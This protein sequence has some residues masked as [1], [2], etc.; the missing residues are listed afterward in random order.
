M[1]VGRILTLVL[2]AWGF[3][4][5]VRAS[6]RT[7]P[8]AGR[9]VF[10]GAATPHATSI[11]LD[12]AALGLGSVNQ[13]Y[14]AVTGALDQLSIQLDGVDPATGASTG[15]GPRVRDAELGAG[16]TIALVYH[17]A[18]DFT[19]GFE[20]HSAPPESF[21]T[22]QRALQ[23]Q[24]LGGGE[25]D[26]AA[27]AG[28]SYKVANELFV[29][30]SLSHQNTLLK[31]DYVRDS[32]LEGATGPSAICNDIAAC[33]FGNADAAETWHVDVRSPTLSTSNL[34]VN[35]GAVVQI[36][37]DV[38]L[39]VAYHTPPESGV[40]TELAGH[41]VI[42]RAPRDVRADPDHL[43]QIRGQ[44][45]VEVQF[46]ASV[47]AELRARL[48][49]ELDLHVGGRWEDLSRLSAY[50]VRAYGSTLPRFG[51]PEWTERPRGLHDAFA[52]WAGAEQIDHGQTLRFGGRAGFETAS[53]TAERT[54]PL[55]ISPA[56][57]TLDV[58]AQL[59]I[60]HGLIA[61]L[62][63]GLQY[64]PTVTV[65]DSA[66]DPRDRVICSAKN[67]DYDAPE[68]A[69]VRNGYAISTAAGT[70]DRLQH[71]VRFALRYEL[72]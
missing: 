72:Q 11:G 62:S 23:Y 44:S 33:G 29:G 68:C 54:S 12:P 43:A 70:Y 51:V 32:A 57:L 61:Q 41:V 55:T 27:T 15:L 38:W 42:D 66:F 28:A 34:R 30:A 5:A 46:P 71:A 64:F 31:L 65:T 22:G 9:A 37:R 58:G 25:R 10:T 24:V 13:L 36:L 59:R 26:L 17:I 18:G 40:Q 60:A 14:V 6:P 35:I 48:P 3:A 2:C 1:A 45:V 69:A 4:T 67:F 20:A 56:S 50:D 7:D 16:A 47:D 52:G 8:T 21:P 39:G 53:V 49:L 19:L 63:Y